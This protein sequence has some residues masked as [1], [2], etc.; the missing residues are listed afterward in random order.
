MEDLKDKLN[1]IWA[2]IEHIHATANE[3]ECTDIDYESQNCIGNLMMLEYNIN[4]SI[5]KLP[6]AEKKP[7]YMES[8][9]ATARRISSEKVWG[10]KEIAERKEQ[11][12]SK[13]SAWLFE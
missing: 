9:F 11:E 7:R 1:T 6:F 13:I 10:V 4:R 5:G 3:D 2:D 12:I 8:K